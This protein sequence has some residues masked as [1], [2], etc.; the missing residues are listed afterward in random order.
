MQRPYKEM[1]LQQSVIKTLK[2]IQGSVAA[3]GGLQN[4]S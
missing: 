1:K 4:I 3:Q 2:T